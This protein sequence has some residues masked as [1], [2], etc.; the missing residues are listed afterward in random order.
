MIVTTLRSSS[1]Q[2]LFRHHLSLTLVTPPVTV[3]LSVHR[4]AALSTHPARGQL[5]CSGLHSV[6]VSRSQLL[7]SA[8]FNDFLVAAAFFYFS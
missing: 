7:A 5:T 4:P 2:R 1:E 6:S 3:T 8:L